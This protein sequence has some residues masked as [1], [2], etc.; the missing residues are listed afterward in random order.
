MKNW[1][2]E[3]IGDTGKSH[4]QGSWWNVMCLTGVDY[5][6]S[7][8]FAPG[9]AFL[10]AGTLSP[11]ATL[12]LIAL[13]L[14]G[15]FPMY[16]KVAELSPNGQGSVALLQD[17][18]PS[19]WGKLLVICLLGFAST[20]FIMTITLCSSDAAKHVVDNPWAP[21][22]LQNQLGLT[23][24]LILLLGAIFLKGFKEAI[25]L[26][27]ILVWIYLALTAAVIGSSILEIVQHPSA[28]SNWTQS[29]AT[30]YSSSW[31]IAALSLLAFPKLALGMSGFETGVAVM[32][33][34][35]G[36]P[37]DTEAHPT[38][39]IKNTKFLLLTAA[40]IMSVF[41]LSSSL[42]TTL[43]IPAEEF[44]ESGK[45]NGRALAYL[46][47]LL[48][49]DGFGTL[50]DIS[51]L[52]ILW[53]AG[54]SAMAGL[55]NLIPRYLP[56][57]GLAPEWVASLR[58]LVLLLTA[59]GLTVV[60]HFN[61]DVDAQAG[62]FATG[63]LVFMTSAAFASTLSTWKQSKRQG[64]YFLLVTIIF[65]YATVNNIIARPDGIKV[66]GVFI[67]AIIASSILSRSLRATE[68]RVGQVSLD[69]KAKE[70]LQQMRTELQGEIRLLAHRP[71][72]TTYEDKEREAREM[73]SLQPEEGNFIFLEVS[74]KDPSDFRSNSLEIEGHEENGHRIWRCI[75]HSVP[76][77]IAALLLHLRND[78]G[79][80]PH[81]YLGWTEG[82]PLNYV[83][84]YVLW[85][86]GET[87]PVT[88]EIL[89]SA[90]PDPNKRPR[91]HVS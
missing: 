87:A 10:Y 14:F 27:V 64:Y 47:H 73:H 11:I 33:N 86:E 9:M 51:T 49:G 34:V 38:G 57:Y 44:A 31:Q 62:A 16:A 2:F 17:L 89:R 32:P 30:T 12:L 13:N 54:A 15:A 43:L 48:L 56:R 28:I 74:P 88:R 24:F 78:T 52:L 77:A 21:Q 50:Y 90:E 42:V 36:Y 8:G 20:G 7:L 81:V 70:F 60:I 68:L 55:L 75:S 6:S 83:F 19:W 45:A 79:Q 26:A 18:L 82:H 65:G 69:S 40:L 41:L 85:G 67:L 5:F 53:F 23:I 1:F 4:Q 25:G 35:K 59:I 66:A 29:L 84:K 71:G 37:T 76:N 61:A 3:R 58:P 72:Y 39:R 22:W 91:V 80:I 63:L 46:A